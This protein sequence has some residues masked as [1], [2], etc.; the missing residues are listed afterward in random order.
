MLAVRDCP[1]ACPAFTDN[2]PAQTDS[3]SVHLSSSPGRKE[4]TKGNDTHCNLAP[5]P[6]ALLKLLLQMLQSKHTARSLSQPCLLFFFDS[7]DHLLLLN[8]P[9]LLA[10]KT[11]LSWFDDCLKIP[12]QKCLPTSKE[13]PPVPPSLRN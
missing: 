4:K 10:S 5:V 11:M 13:V 6:T 9:S 1:S 2:N 8:P 12:S 7:T 3:N